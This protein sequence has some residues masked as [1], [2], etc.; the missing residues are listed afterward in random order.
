MCSGHGASCLLS[1][2]STNHSCTAHL[3][4]DEQAYSTTD[5][6]VHALMLQTG[7]CVHVYMYT[8]ARPCVLEKTHAYLGGLLARATHTHGT[9]S[10]VNEVYRS[11]PGRHQEWSRSCRFYPALRG[12]KTRI[13]RRPGSEDRPL[14]GAE[15]WTT[16]TKLS[17]FDNRAVVPIPTTQARWR[18][19]LYISILNT[20]H[21]YNLYE[22]VCS[23]HTILVEKTYLEVNVDEAQKA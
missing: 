11:P 13:R 7:A 17:L 14:N 8:Y 1:L 16:S 5:V 2:F 21:A 20:F 6:H 23:H 15:S 12:R 10:N 19:T 18:L 3:Y 9:F 22:Y 4:K